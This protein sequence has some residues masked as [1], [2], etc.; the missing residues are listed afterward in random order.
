MK[1]SF[2]QHGPRAMTFLD[3]AIALATVALLAA[4]LL[5]A[6]T[7]SRHRPSR[8]NCVSNLKQIGLALRMWSNDHGDKF[9][10]T[11]SMKE[12]GTR[13]CTTT[14]EFFRHFE[15]TSNELS[16]PKV[17]CCS[18]DLQRV[19][20]TTFATNLSNLNVSYFLG[21]DADMGKPQSILSGDR[22]L[23]TNGIILSGVLALATNSPV[24]WA[25]GIHKDGGNLGL[26]D[27]SAMQMSASDLKRFVRDT[28]TM[29]ARVAIP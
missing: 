24:S 11:V 1:T 17:L 9:P 13:E 15:A 22:T 2:S 7:R 20:A 6:L 8:L 25:K 18:L 5:P 3:V 4:V 21:L 29:P 26:S 19:K 10:W 14:A 28:A 27:G 12:G 16:S 23:T